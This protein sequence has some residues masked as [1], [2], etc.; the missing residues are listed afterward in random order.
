MR[1]TKWDKMEWAFGKKEEEA[2]YLWSSEKVRPLKDTKDSDE[3]KAKKKNSPLLNVCKRLRA[4]LGTSWTFPSVK[5]H[6]CVRKRS[7]CPC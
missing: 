7:E 4:V 5:A 2:W 3:W 6:N 1:G